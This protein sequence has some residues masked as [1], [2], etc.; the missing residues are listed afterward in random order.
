MNEPTVSVVIRAFNCDKYIGLALESILAQTFQE[1]EIIVVDDNSTDQTEAIL[2]TYAQHDR[3]IKIFK[4]VTNQGPVKTMNI[5]LRQARGKFIAVQDADDLSL[6]HRLKTQV[7]FLN[8]HPNIALVGGGSIGIDEEGEQIE[9]T[10]WPR[11]RMGP[12]EVKKYL[13]DG[14]T[15][16][17][18]SMMFRWACIEAIG[19]YDEFFSAAHDYDML[20][21]M[22]NEFDVTYYEK[23]LVQWRWLNNGITGSKKQS[24]AAFVELARMRHEAKTKGKSL[25]LQQEYNRL[26]AGEAVVDR[27]YRNRPLSD[28]A[29][30]YGIGILLL[31]KGKA[32]KARKRF[33]KAIRHHGSM[34]IHLRAFIWYGLSFYPNIIHSKF[35]KTIRN[36]I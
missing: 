2:Q 5:G 1:F 36:S 8:A 14:H 29:Y 23:I 26:M 17:H 13:E 31:D 9:I 34:N 19:F 22:A 15:F 4:N 3:R 30:Y 20:T 24:Q 6:P 16:A 28:A 7:N 10:H 21:R 27:S 33:L 18:S 12:E 11:H 25:D 35:I 32:Q